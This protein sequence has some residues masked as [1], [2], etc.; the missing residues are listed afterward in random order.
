[1]NM[2]TTNTYMVERELINILRERENNELPETLLTLII[3]VLI[4]AK[5]KT[6]VSWAQ[7]LNNN[8]VDNRTADARHIAALLIYEETGNT[9]LSRNVIGH[10]FGFKSGNIA[11]HGIS[12]R[13]ENS[14]FE[15]KFNKVKEY[16]ETIVLEEYDQQI[17]F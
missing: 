10:F 5:V 13:L 11:R 2:T 7:M 15:S 16:Y 4:A 17:P 12:K 9:T 1:M 3:K 14:Y 8:K 6:G